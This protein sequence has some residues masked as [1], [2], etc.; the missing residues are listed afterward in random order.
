MFDAK[1]A[2]YDEYNDYNNPKS[3]TNRLWKIG[4][5]LKGDDAWSGRDSK[6]REGA[7]QN[8][9]V[10][11]DT[12]KKFVGLTPTKPRS[13][14]IVE[15]E[16][17]L[18]EL[19]SAR[20]GSKQITTKVPE[21]PKSYEQYDDNDIKQLLAVK[22]EKPELSEREKFLMG[23][24]ESGKAIDLR[25]KA[26]YFKQDDVISCPY[27]FQHVSA[28]YKCDLV[29]SIEK[30]LS[31]TVSDHQKVLEGYV[32]GP[33]VID[34]TPFTVLESY[35]NCIDLIEKINTAISNN[36]EQIRKKIENPYEGIE[37]EASTVSVDIKKL[38]EALTKLE[39][40][41]EAFNKEAADPTPIVQKLN[42]I[43]SQIAHYDVADLVG[44][45]DEQ[46][47]AY[48]IVEK[49]FTDAQTDYETKKKE[50]E[51]LEAQR[52]NVH[53]ALGI[54]NSCMKYIFFAEDRLRIDYVDGE[55]RLYTNGKS[56]KPC[57]VS[58]GERN[59]IGLSYFFASIMEGQEEK[60][61]FNKEYLLVI[62][63][64][65]SSYDTEN[66]IGILSFLKYIFGQFLEG[67]K[68]T[69]A[70]VMTHDLMTFFDV[71]KLFEEIVDSCKQKRYPNPPKFNR[72]EIHNCGIVP[73]RYNNR[74]EYTEI[75]KTIFA[76]GNGEMVEYEMV[77]G[78]MMRQALEAFSTFQ[79]RKGIENVSTDSTILALLPEPEYRSYYRNLMYRLVLHGGS[80]KEEQIKAMKDY[81]FFSIISETE[82]KRT[83][84]EVLCFIYLLNKRHVLEHLKEVNNVE[85]VLER[86]CAE[87]KTRA[88][89]P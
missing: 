13:E 54:I 60:D 25:Q 69:K 7:R 52:K 17:K 42:E 16:E 49:A 5:A 20:S 81:E 89:M 68:D 40:E 71:H 23:L 80:H 43:N 31:K 88:A 21:L 73:F 61:V 11:D 24:V 19:E 67:N 36:N 9:P 78:N 50:A 58:V 63:D 12:Y 53:V 65:I 48:K 75:L 3:P 86:W 33:I 29:S 37:V 76:Y 84:K 2:T 66:R 8:T 44:E 10:R 62:D 72:F 28:E 85:I 55:Y 83:A 38:T 27:C 79:Y 34:T 39:I 46:V 26:I 41:R 56:V 18:K 47:E 14:L 6:L 35:Q 87:V 70:L 32:Y 77:I 30:V 57:D 74:Q 45:Y 4:N 22:I 15:F 64:P 1:K 59:I 82:K 51:D